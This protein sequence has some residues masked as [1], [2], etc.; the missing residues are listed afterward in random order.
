MQ[1]TSTI[2][3]DNAPWWIHLRPNKWPNYYKQK[4]IPINCVSSWPVGEVC[5]KNLLNLWQF[6]GKQKIKFG[7]SDFWSWCGNLLPHPD[8]LYSWEFFEQ[9]RDKSELKTIE[10]IVRT[11]IWT[12]NPKKWF[13]LHIVMYIMLIRAIKTRPWT[14]HTYQKS[15]ESTNPQTKHKLQAN[16]QM[17]QAF[18][19]VRAW[20]NKLNV[21]KLTRAC[22]MASV[23][24]EEFPVTSPAASA[25]L[26]VL[27]PLERET[28]EVC[29]AGFVPEYLR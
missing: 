4:Q 8:Q 10:T 27:A 7:I 2:G 19:Q 29:N 26:S 17:Q 14:T 22:R 24:D 9:T 25:G 21:V 15:R 3:W 16:D 11:T 28:L 5:T 1:L 6:T 20:I 13:T 23:E 18:N 12:M